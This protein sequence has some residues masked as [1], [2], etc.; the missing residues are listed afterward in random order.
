MPLINIKTGTEISENPTAKK[1]ILIQFP[2]THFFCKGLK[3]E[4]NLWD[5]SLL[6]PEKETEK[7]IKKDIKTAVFSFY[8]N[9]FLKTPININKEKLT[10]KNLEKLLKK[11]TKTKKN[12]NTKKRNINNNSRNNQA[13]RKRHS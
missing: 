8:C 7:I 9:L 4:N 13:N 10:E 6:N 3:K 11:I 1:S 12:G 5:I 2:N